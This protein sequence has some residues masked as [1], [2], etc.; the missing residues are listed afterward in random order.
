MSSVTRHRD[1]WQRRVRD[2]SEM[3]LKPLRDD[4]RLRVEICIRLKADLLTIGVIVRR[5]GKDTRSLVTALRKSP[6]ID[7]G[8]QNDRMIKLKEWLKQAVDLPVKTSR[9]GVSQH[10]VFLDFLVRCS[11]RT[12]HS[13]FLHFRRQTPFLPKSNDSPEL[14]F[15]FTAASEQ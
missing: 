13:S 7:S 14:R 4:P 3:T 10:R 12:R 15:G 1:H 6:W 2:G 5:E 8:E 9:N 11:S